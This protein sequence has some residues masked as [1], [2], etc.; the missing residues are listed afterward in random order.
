MGVS[1][2][3]DLYGTDFKHAELAHAKE[4]SKYWELK[5]LSTCDIHMLQCN[6]YLFLFKVKGICAIGKAPSH[7]FLKELHVLKHM[8]TYTHSSI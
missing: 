6:I 8:F 4:D 1:I 2:Q 3:F 5:Y 7:T